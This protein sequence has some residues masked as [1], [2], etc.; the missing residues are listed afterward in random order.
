M[1]GS[2][3]ICSQG[4]TYFP[5]FSLFTPCHVFIFP[6][7]FFYPNCVI[8]PSSLH[9][10]K[11]SC[12]IFTLIS[13]PSPSSYR[14][15]SFVFLTLYPCSFTYSS[16]SCLSQSYSLVTPFISLQL[17]FFL[18]PFFCFYSPSLFAFLPTGSSYPSKPLLLLNAFLFCLIPLLLYPLPLSAFVRLLLPPL[19]LCSLLLLY[20]LFCFSLPLL[21]PFTLVFH[22]LTCFP[23]FFPFPF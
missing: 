23:L 14:L 8:F 22:L 12:L 5:F 21:L 10:P 2:F 17:L 1:Y 18:L 4:F 11:I 15:S 9:I 20:P 16:L 3:F 19:P 6:F 7:R 13:S